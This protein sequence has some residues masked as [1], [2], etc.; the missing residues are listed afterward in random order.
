MLKYKGEYLRSSG[1]IHLYKQSQKNYPARTFLLTLNSK[2][3]NLDDF[4]FDVY[5]G[6]NHHNTYPHDISLEPLICWDF[7]EMLFACSDTV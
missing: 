5:Y 7:L 4:L 1:Y 3:E 2:T 6:A